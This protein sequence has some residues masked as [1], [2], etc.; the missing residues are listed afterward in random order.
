MSGLIIKFI[1]L[2]INNILNLTLLTF[3]LIV[4][5][6]SL[7]NHAF[8]QSCSGGYTAP[9]CR[10]TAFHYQETT[11][12][13]TGSNVFLHNAYIQKKKYN[14]QT[15]QLANN[16]QSHLKRQPRESSFFIKSYVC[17]E[18]QLSRHRTNISKRYQ[19]TLINL[20]RNF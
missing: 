8:Q 2:L 16:F 9:C 12:A 19:Q 5:E 20:R 11:P 18:M 14:V 3:K 4:S 17:L 7:P 13:F 15:K 1:V 6:L 10:T